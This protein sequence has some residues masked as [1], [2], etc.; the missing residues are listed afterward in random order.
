MSTKVSPQKKHRGPGLRQAGSW[1]ALVAATTLGV[2]AA[3]TV[4]TTIRS[5]DQRI[6]DSAEYLL[7][8]QT[9]DRK[10]KKPVGSAQRAVTGAELRSGVSVSVLELREKQPAG[11]PM[12]VAWL[13]RGAR[14]LEFDGRQA[15]PSPGSLY[16]EA[17]L[18]S[19]HPV[20]IALVAA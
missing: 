3:H 9:Y 2:E 13:E 11:E 15:R 10:G 14:Q 17:R 18:E 1:I 8:V 19:E 7:V 4:R 5:D 12:V 16:G 6:E 20:Q